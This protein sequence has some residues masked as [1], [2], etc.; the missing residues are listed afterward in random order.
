MIDNLVMNEWENIDEDYL[1]LYCYSEAASMFLKHNFENE[2]WICNY[3]LL[4]QLYLTITIILSGTFEIFQLKMKNVRLNIITD[5]K[6]LK[7][8]P[9]NIKYYYCP[10][11][12]TIWNI[13]GEKCI[14]PGGPQL[15]GGWPGRSNVVVIL[16]VRERE[17]TSSLS[18][19]S[20]TSRG[21]LTTVLQYFMFHHMWR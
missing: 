20:T 13:L 6:Y 7:K 12:E 15:I 16:I 19:L 5:W 10:I 2:E 17:N 3:K 21:Q 18:S 8:W 14:A 4:I 1:C 9:Q 11:C